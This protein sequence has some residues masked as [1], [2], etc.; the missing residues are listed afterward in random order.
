MMA[1]MEDVATEMVSCGLAE[2]VMEGSRG[3]RWNVGCGEGRFFF[4]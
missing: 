3:G 2:M 1:S 4:S